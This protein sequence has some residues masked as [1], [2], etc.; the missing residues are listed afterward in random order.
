M[1]KIEKFNA[2][3]ETAIK[4]QPKIWFNVKTKELFIEQPFYSHATNEEIEYVG[5]IFNFSVNNKP[6]VIVL[7]AT[8]YENI[9]LVQRMQSLY[10]K[11]SEG[12]IKVLFISKVVSYKDMAL[13]KAEKL[14][15]SYIANQKAY[16][17]DTYTITDNTKYAGRSLEAQAMISGNSDYVKQPLLEEKY[18]DPLELLDD[19]IWKPTNKED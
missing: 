3:V 17:N 9:T 12:G 6:V 15:F 16:D 13:W 1:G 11:L 8:D 7:D 5:K 2:I 18:A 14:N 10:L 4:N 19:T